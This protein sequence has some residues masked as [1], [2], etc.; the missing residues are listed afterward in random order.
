MRYGEWIVPAAPG[1]NLAAQ[2]EIHASIRADVVSSVHAVG[3]P[4]KVIVR[5]RQHQSVWRVTR[6]FVAAC[7]VHSTI[8][9]GEQFADQWSIDR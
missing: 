7:I 5:Q 1:D 9:K 6:G 3:T 2:P 4:C 8:P